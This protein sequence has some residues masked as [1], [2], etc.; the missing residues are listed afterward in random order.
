[1]NIQENTSL[2]PYNTFGIDAKARFFTK[3][4]GLKE[5]K[6]A[7]L[8][9]ESQT[10]PILILGGGSNI[11]LTQDFTGLVIKLELKG[12]KVVEED[13]E[14]V[15]VSVG[16][17]ENWHEF[18]LFA[19][20]QNWAGIENLSLIPGT[21]G[22][23][24]MQNIGAYG[25]EIQ[26]VF[27]H[28]KALNRKTLELETFSAEECQFGYRES[29]FKHRLKDKYIICEVV[30]Q[31]SKIPLIN[32]SYGAIKDTLAEMKAENPGI[33]EVSDAVIAIRQSKLPNPAEIGNA[34]SFFK[35][36]TI[37]EST[38]EKL[39]D[40]FPEI[41]GYK[42]DE[43]IKVPAAWLIDQ[44]GWKGFRRNDIGVHNKQALVLVNF[45]KG[46]GKEIQELSQEIQKSVEEKF[47]IKLSPEVNFI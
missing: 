13:S 12:I 42:V 17:G 2:K 9:A 20:A 39:K 15:L 41:P 30:F 18:V 28:L 4:S 47:G 16:A 8:F 37:S 5:L 35:N 6:E 26:Q 45:G 40:Q 10:I 46:K 31:L 29:V 24:P 23:S 7:L 32:I 3:V 44:A 25:V 14:K 34:G 1:M 33:K 19:I 21:V 36:P 43:V 38:F 22:A 11:L 27:Y